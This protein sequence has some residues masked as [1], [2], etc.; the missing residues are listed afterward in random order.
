[1]SAGGEIPPAPATSEQGG[2]LDSWKEIAAYFQ[3]D[4]R[5]VRRWEAAEGLPVHRHRHRE[6]GSVYAYAPELDAWWSSRLSSEGR[7]PNAAPA[8]VAPRVSTRWRWGLACVALL[9]AAAAVY[10]AV[11]LRAPLGPISGRP[12]RIVVLPFESPKGDGAD[13]PL[14]DVVAGDIVS[15]LAR[16]APES[17]AVVAY[18]SASAYRGTGKRVGQIGRELRVDYLLEGGLRRAAAG[19][20]VTVRLVATSDETLLKVWEY[21]RPSDTLAGLADD[22]ADGVAKSVGLTARQRGP[23][24]AGGHPPI[25][26]EAYDLYLRAR[27]HLDRRTGQLAL[28]Q[29]YLQEAL[30]RAPDFAPAHAAL[31]DA[32]SR[33]ARSRPDLEPDAWARAEAS[34][35]RAL[36][37]DGR[38]A[39]GHVVVGTIALFRDW[40]WPGAEASFRRAVALDPEEPEARNGYAAYFRAAGLMDEAIVQRQ[41]ALSAD[42]VNVTLI[43]RLGDDYTFARQLDAAISQFR[44]ALELEPDNRA[45]LDSLADAC[46]RRGLEQEALERRTR[47]LMLQGAKSDAEEFERVF[48]SEGYRAAE[49]WLDRKHLERFSRNPSVNA[50]NLAFTYARLGDKESAFRCL[51]EAFARRDPGL[52][53]LRVDPDVDNLRSDPRFAA[54]VRRLGPIRRSVRATNR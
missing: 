22:V 26:G 49:R 53:L 50:W 31:G 21:T 19:L 12:L 14:G 54:L 3:R 41:R 33:V 36:A 52:L 15:K 17:L 43:T 13:E 51:E 6:R 45:A 4:V 9:T 37:L 48:R 44:R 11:R 2:R 38:L 30:A 32:L 34:A 20:L 18:T 35:K 42:P 1:M 29:R 40:D 25:D 39:L 5:T 24:T 46:G 23:A 47:L 28:A 8:P 7:A 27:Y 10:F 16:V